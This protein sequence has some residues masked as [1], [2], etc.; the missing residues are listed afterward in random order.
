MWHRF[1]TGERKELRRSCVAIGRARSDL[2]AQSAKDKECSLN[3]AQRRVKNYLRQRRKTIS[4]EGRQRAVHSRSRKFVDSEANPS[5]TVG[6]LFKQQRRACSGLFRI[7][8]GNA[9]YFL[10]SNIPMPGRYSFLSS[11]SL[12]SQDSEPKPQSVIYVHLRKLWLTVV[13]LAF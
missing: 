4:A 6:A 3:S 5:L 13:V 2:D 7:V 10:S 9:G 1:P 8:P 12:K 11:P